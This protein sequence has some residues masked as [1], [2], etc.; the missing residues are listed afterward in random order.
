MKCFSEKIAMLLSFMAIC[1]MPILYGCDSDEST[2]N[3]FPEYKW[4]TS[5]KF[6]NAP[7]GVPVV[8][9]PAQG[10]TFSFKCNEYPAIH[11]EI[12]SEV[13]NLR[14]TETTFAYYYHPND[15]PEYTDLH[16]KGTYCEASING[17]SL[18]V[19]IAPNT[20]GKTRY[21]IVGTYAA[22]DG[23]GTVRFKQDAK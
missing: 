8:L 3:G 4:E 11:L 14:N 23:F 13:D 9:V 7:E 22:I 18:T 17:A 10:G 15:K 12:V 1:L 20:T 5:S 2:I 19:T 6:V 21:V 16:I